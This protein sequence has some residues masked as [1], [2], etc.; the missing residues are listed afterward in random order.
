[1]SRAGAFGRGHAE[2]LALA[3]NVELHVAR[4]LLDASGDRSKSTRYRPWGLALGM[5]FLGG[6]VFAGVQGQLVA[7]VSRVNPP[8]VGELVPRQIPYRG[9][10]ERDGVPVSTPQSFT[11][12][13][14]C[15]S[16]PPAVRNGGI[17]SEKNAKSGIEAAQLDKVDSERGP[18]TKEDKVITDQET[19]AL[20]FGRSSLE[21]FT[22]VQVL[23]DAAAADAHENNFE[24]R[25]GLYGIED[26]DVVCI[27]DNSPCGR[28]GA[29]RGEML[30]ALKKDLEAEGLPVVAEGSYPKDG[31]DAHYTR[32]LL[33]PGLS[34]FD[35][36]RD[37]FRKHVSAMVDRLDSEGP[38]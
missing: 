9:Y 13:L 21:A 11:F 26:N 1:M 35:L 34:E 29:M 14:E 28:D 22:E 16:D 32:V 36:I 25:R 30:V 37:L 20:L 6:T 17:M 8:G 7:F 19:I 38:T 10:L 4:T 23:A 12:R 3:L 18:S 2:E 24:S 5:L 27:Y 31:S 33:V 15:V